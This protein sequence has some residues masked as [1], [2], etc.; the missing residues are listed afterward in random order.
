MVDFSTLNHLMD[1]FHVMVFYM[2]MKHVKCDIKY[3]KDLNCTNSVRLENYLL[4]SDP[5]DALKTKLS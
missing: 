2:L 5:C 1:F 4:S 3:H